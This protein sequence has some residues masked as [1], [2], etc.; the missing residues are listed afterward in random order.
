MSKDLNRVKTVYGVSGGYVNVFPE[1]IIQ[2]T[3]PTTN[4]GAELG[5]V[6]INKS[7]DNAYMAVDV[8]ASGTTWID[9]GG[10]DPVF[11]DLK[12]T[13]TVTFSGI[14]G[15]ATKGSTLQINS[16]GVLSE[17]DN[18]DN[19]EIL[20]GSSAGI[21]A[22]AALTAG[23]GIS[24]LNDANSVTITA[25][26][27]TASS[28][29]TDGGGSASPDGTGATTIAGGSNITT[30]GAASTVTINLDA[31]PSVA[32]SLTAGVD[33]NMS[34][35]DMTITADTDAAKT[36][37]LHADGGTSET[38]D[39]HSDQGTGADSIYVH[40][41]AGGLTF[42]SGLN[43]ADA[44]NF[45]ASD[46]AGGIDI[47]S[48]TN[49][50]KV[51]STGV[52]DFNS[53][54]ATSGAIV[55]E[56]SD[57][58]GG[59]DVNAGTAGFIVDTTGVASIDAAAASNFTVTGAFDFT[60]KSTAGS[61]I[62]ESG[63]VATDS[64]KINASNAAG[65]IDIDSGTNGTTIDSTGA[66]SVGAAAASDFTV[67]GA[68]DLDFESTAGSVNVTAGEAAA[69]AIYLN[70]TA[71]GVDITANSADLDLLSTLGS[72]NAT[73]TEDAANAIY[74]HANGGTSETIKIHS[75]LGTSGSSIDVLSDVG[76]ISLAATAYANDAAIKLAAGAGG[77]DIDG[78]LQVNIASS[79]VAADAVVINASAGGVDVTAA[80]NDLDLT[81]T[82]GS[83]IVTANEAAAD[84]IYL[85]ASAGGVDIDANSADIDITSTLGSVNV[86][87]TEDAANALYLHA[88]GGTSETIKIHSDLGTS[89]S[90]IDVVSDVGGI[91]LGA[92]AYANDTAIKLAAGA[93]GVDVDAAM[94]INVTSSE[95]QADAVRLY[96]SDA[97]GGLDVDYGTGGCSFVG[98]NGAFTVES[99]TA[100]VSIGADAAAHDVTVGSITGAATLTH[101][102]GTGAMTFTA[103]GIFDVN[104]TDAVTIDS[105]AGTLG[106]GEGAND[107]DINIGTAGDRTITVGSDSGLLSYVCAHQNVA[108]GATTQ[109]TE[110]DAT[111]GAVVV[112]ATQLIGGYTYIGAAGAGVALTMPA[113]AD[114]QAELATHNITSAAGLRLTPIWI[115]VTDANNLTVTAAAGGTVHGTAAVND[116]TAQVLPIFS[117]AA[118]I[119]FLVIQG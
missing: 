49:G 12:A 104:A 29:P 85:N 102:S 116:G 61:V 92:T 6:W 30:S 9:I 51:D 59:V 10:G 24:I 48:G 37:Y 21:P 71:G 110:R 111:G 1:P 109:L 114:V 88:N 93:G 54:A 73:A 39:I 91:S 117:G 35:G 89:G 50:I 17:I 22:F 56:A 98:A 66:V 72:I 118:T 27:A 2:T 45:V 75:D 84:A 77:V 55:I 79:E 44:I 33:L 95:A 40:S 64:I 97:A 11:E 23:A 5:T 3:A 16:S 68:F 57:T 103:G 67:T 20:I 8:T 74:L 4:D 94:Q 31:S 82:L 86:V 43:S 47:D 58:A 62:V 41:D 53:S 90:S 119:D 19:G 42:T 26:G 38:I 25:T 81:A 87:A 15:A 99:G 52:I 107:F 36:I 63:E 83:V 96:A 101:Q 80:A 7:S 76:G 105:T 106:L 100:A 18:G 46:V 69:D 108:T 65:G 113:A 115:E 112:T 34:S 13:G 78:A 70:A 32:G 60:L 14:A 28:F